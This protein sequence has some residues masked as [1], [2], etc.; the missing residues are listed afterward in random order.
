MKVLVCG[1]DGR[2]AEVALAA[3]YD[4][5]YVPVGPVEDALTALGL[6]DQEM[7]AVAIV[8]L[9][10]MAGGT[11]AWLAEK[12]AER[13]VEL[14]CLTDGTLERGLSCRP[15]ASMGKPVRQELLARRLEAS[16]R[17][18]RNARRVAADE[19][20]WDAA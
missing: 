1:N 16:L 17:R 14:I 19:P 18:R 13:A 3:V 10:A 8:D 15:E 20:Q 9:S 6:A 12:L 5:G 7:P 2:S 4:A 11:G